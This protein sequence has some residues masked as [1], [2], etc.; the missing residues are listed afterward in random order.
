M[1][2]ARLFGS[3]S[4]G[5]TSPAAQKSQVRLDVKDKTPRVY[6]GQLCMALPFPALRTKPDDDEL[7]YLATAVDVHDAS[8]PDAV[9]CIFFG[10][11]NDE[12][13][14]VARLV[15]ASAADKEAVVV[16]Y[17][18]ALAA[19]KR[20]AKEDS[21][22]VVAAAFDKVRR[23]HRLGVSG[24]I[25]FS[26]AKSAEGKMLCE[27]LIARTGEHSG[28][29]LVYMAEHWEEVC[30]DADTDG[31]GTISEEE[32]VTIWDNALLG[33]TSYVATKL[34]QLGAPP[35]LYR[36]DLCVVIPA[37]EHTDPAQ[38]KKE[39]LASY[40]DASHAVFFDG[41]S[42]DPITILK[43]RPASAVQREVA[44]AQYTKAA[45]Q[46]MHLARR[47][48][49]D[50]M[51][52]AIERVRETTGGLG[53][54]GSGPDDGPISYP[55]EE[56][57]G[58]GRRASSAGGV[59]EAHLLLDYLADNFSGLKGHSKYQRWLSAQWR[60][61]CAQADADGSG[62][63][64]FEQ[65]LQIWERLQLEVVRTVVQKLA[66]LGVNPVAYT[67]TAGDLCVVRLPPEPGDPAS[68]PPHA[69]QLATYVDASHAVLFAAGEDAPRPIAS[70]EPAPGAERNVSIVQWHKILDGCQR[71]AARDAG[72]VVA[73]AIKE[74]EA[75]MGDALGAEGRIAYT[76][77]EVGTE[78]KGGELLLRALVGQMGL[79]ADEPRSVQNLLAQW[80]LG[81]READ[82][83]G[84]G[85]VSEA[86]AV[87]VWKPLLA[88]FLESVQGKVAKLDRT[89]EQDKTV[90]A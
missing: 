70:V 40:L 5:K 85:A 63:V 2:S 16:K 34:E 41:V 21:A 61:A 10:D 57:N 38:P 24:K 28:P 71:L 3:R 33:I 60:A 83:E 54:M 12:P 27:T 6:P 69:P 48:S 8:N 52:R 73:R 66:L 51:R 44:I 14:A 45:T 42:E 64:P 84:S 15:P 23:H 80:R 9:H 36:G 62:S 53:T 74:T 82:T 46:C 79:L 58:A 35:R 4:P 67:L 77:A 17:E 31:S 59:R 72:K 13:Q 76:E 50:V 1:R 7:M 81:C 78:T 11:G 49:A 18:M 75:Q 55:R 43:A 19:C 88:R 29:S 30:R 37:K 89:S 90:T 56:G 26:G 87:R 20:L 32:A 22:A 25:N 65:A 68:A 86:Q 47:K 39:Y